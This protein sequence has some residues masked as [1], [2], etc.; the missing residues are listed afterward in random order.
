MEQENKHWNWNNSYLTVNQQLYSK[1]VP[2]YVELPCLLLYNKNLADDLG[3]PSELSSDAISALAG[4]CV[5]E[6]SEP[7]LSLTWVLDLRS[8]DYKANETGVCVCVCVCVCMCVCV[9]DSVWLCVR[10][11]HG[12]ICDTK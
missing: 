4:N 11:C 7:L 12:T 8:K 3:L 6:G 10:A 5:L 2:S 9:C 1:V